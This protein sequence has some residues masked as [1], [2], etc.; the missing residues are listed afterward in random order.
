MNDKLLTL[1]LARDGL[2]LKVSFFEG[3]EKSLRPYEMHE[4]GWE[5]VE[6]SC[7]ELLANLE[8]SN[9]A[10]NV[11]AEILDKLK[12]SGRLLF[13]LL[14][15]TQA[16]AK[17]VNATV[18]VLALHLE[19]SL[20]HVPWELLHDG[21]DFLCRRFAVGRIASTRQALTARSVREFN[22]PFKVLIIADPRGELAGCYREGLDIKAYLDAR[23]ETF[24]V[25]FKSYPVDIAFV[26]KNLRDYDIVHY[27]GHAI[28]D[29]HNPGKSGWLLSDGMLTADGIA[30]MGGL[31]AM[32]AL[33]FAN[34]CRS[35]LTN[36]WR[37]DENE[38]QI[39]GLANAFL[40]AGV[41]H[42]LGTLW[43]VVD[44]PGARFA[45]RF[46]AAIAAGASVGSAL[47]SARQGNPSD[48]SNGL[49]WANYLLYGDPDSQFGAAKETAAE[50]RTKMSLR[51]FWQSKTPSSRRGTK[52][53]R[54]PQYVS[55][56][57][58]LIVLSILAGLSFS[59]FLIS[60]PQMPVT[61]ASASQAIRASRVSS[62]PL[63][64]PLSLSMEVIGQRKEP[65]GSYSEV[66]VQEGSVLQSGDHFQV[67]V[68]TNKRAHVYLL[69]FD[70]RGRAKE[71]F[72]DP[73]IE[74]AG[75]VE[76]GQRIA[77]P[78]QDLWFWLDENTGTETLYTV[79]SE[80]PLPN[81]REL[82]HKMEA[83]DDAGKKRASQ[84]IKN[85]IPIVQRGVGGIT[86]G[87]TVTYSLSSGDRIEKVTEVV[88][89]SGSVV[90][91][92]SFQHR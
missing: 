47:R 3:S 68:E 16:K 73:K 82:L 88:S 49:T 76:G 23:R 86:K 46:Y 91:A 18:T 78:E 70:S 10:T 33:V 50:R 39:F 45:E 9:R 75:F 42:Y 64:E 6:Q 24:Q 61:Q 89:G 7:K 38:Q 69:L 48:E 27:A 65:D 1:Q 29:A 59:R 41:Q 37:S 57:A 87:K 66:I 62:A 21:R 19:D 55:A 32:P 28:Y 44:D 40:L 34:A 56:A 60:Q 31:E 30:A 8:L 85:K 25:D 54:S 81:V 13:D 20:V 12:K 79:A 11:P 51:R 17:L 5:L 83:A 77:I 72:P 53:W 84:E 71:L 15:P 58:V 80:K 35:G 92:L 36:E 67:E 26:R 14:I 90:R 63:L 52:N 74:Q 22:A 2:R 43:D 4:V